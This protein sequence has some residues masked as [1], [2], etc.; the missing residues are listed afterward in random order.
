MGKAL[1]ITVFRGVS[2]VAAGLVAGACDIDIPC[3]GRCFEYTV[4]YAAPLECLIAGGGNLEIPFTDNDPVGYRGRFCFN[5]ASVPKVMQAI[6]HL[7]GDGQLSELAAD[8]Q[9]AYI[10][11]VNAVKDDIQAE[12]ITAA[13]G[14]CMNEVQVCTGIAADMYEQLVVDETCVLAPAGTEPVTLPPGQVCEAVGDDRGTGSG[15]DGG[16]CME[17][18]TTNVGAD[19]TATSGGVDETSG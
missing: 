9:S 17:L 6:E 3:P 18:A 4:E 14:Q 5:S 12:C 2:F 8:V 1:V 7:R 13:P 11:T 15:E 16:P 19:E 10:S